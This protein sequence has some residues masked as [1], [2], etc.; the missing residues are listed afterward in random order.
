MRRDTARTHDVLL[1]AVGTLLESQGPT[2]TLPELARA[3]DVGQ[4]TVYRHF[5][6]VYDAYGQ[7][8]RRLLHELTDLLVAVPADLD[9]HT[10][11][12]RACRAWLDL[13]IRW[14]RSAASIRSTEGFIERVARAEPDS[15]ALHDALAGFVTELITAGKV[16]EQDVSAA[17]LVWISLFDERNVIDLREGHRW[18][19]AQVENYLTACVLGAL[20]AAGGDAPAPAI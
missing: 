14:G 10:R 8:Y 16:G 18:K 11:F 15:V 6:D 1:D 17:V 19:K 9:A 12:T 5:S 3:A 7:F 13:V 4:A 2:F 20:R